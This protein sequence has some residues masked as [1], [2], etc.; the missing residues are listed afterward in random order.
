MTNLFYLRTAG[1]KQQPPARPSRPRLSKCQAT[2]KRKRQAVVKLP[3]Q[4]AKRI[5]AIILDLKRGVLILN[6]HIEAELEHAGIRNPSHFAYPLS[7]R[8]LL[9]RRE[10][11]KT[12]IA[13]LSDR[14]PKTNQAFANIPDTATTSN[15]MSRDQLGGGKCSNF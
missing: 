15:E 8:A 9:V 3:E 5:E 14:L 11:L 10:N 6:H 1:T 12:T 13:V 2:E 4:E 7:A